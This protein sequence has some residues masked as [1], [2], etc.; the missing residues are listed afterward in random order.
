[1]RQSAYRPTFSP[2]SGVDEI[3][4]YCLRPWSGFFRYA[5]FGDVIHNEFREEVF[6]S[7]ISEAREQEVT[8]TVSRL[9]SRQ[10]EAG[11]E[12]DAAHLLLGGDMVTG[13]NIYVNQQADIRENLDEQLDRAFEVYIEQIKRLASDFPALQ[14]VC[15]PG[16]HG[17]LR[18]TP[19]PVEVARQPA[20]D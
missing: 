20:L 14:V 11:I 8:D 5:H 15:Q 2:G 17:A 7:G 6:N 18:I 9:V 19:G 16:N 12:Y 4:S 13:E 3:P 1:V 10:N